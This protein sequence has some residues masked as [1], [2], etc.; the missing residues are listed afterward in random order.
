MTVQSIHTAAHH[1]YLDPMTGCGVLVLPVPDDDVW[2][3]GLGTC[4]ASAVSL[5]CSDLDA[6]IRALA[7]V[8]WTPADPEE[9]DFDIFL[10]VGKDAEG[11]VAVALVGA[12]PICSQP[13]MSECEDAHVELLRHAGVTV[14]V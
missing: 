7:L 13:T 1:A 8:G 2:C 10:H 12:D 5:H 14:F 4:P 3:H 9:P 6:M 11:R